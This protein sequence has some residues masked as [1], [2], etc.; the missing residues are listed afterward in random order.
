MDCFHD[1]FKENSAVSGK[2]ENYRQGK[3]GES[4]CDAEKTKR[5]GDQRANDR[6]QSANRTAA[7]F[8]FADF[9]ILDVRGIQHISA[10]PV[11]RKTD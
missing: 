3:Q 6:H 8:S 4:E 9:R 1:F 10:H 11:E 2:V 5:N 7:D